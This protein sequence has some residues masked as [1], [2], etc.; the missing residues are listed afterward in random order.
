MREGEREEVRVVLGMVDVVLGQGWYG[1]ET[2]GVEW[3]LVAVWVK[4]CRVGEGSSRGGVM[5]TILGQS[6]T[7]RSSLP[8][9]C[10]CS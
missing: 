1:M 4:G 7:T 8:P 9:S 5:E 3:F 6:Q 10:L 2:K